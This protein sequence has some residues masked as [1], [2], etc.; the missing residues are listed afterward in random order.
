MICAFAYYKAWD[1]ETG[2]HSKRTYVRDACEKGLF[3]DTPDTTC[4]QFLHIDLNDDTAM[5]ARHA[6]VGQSRRKKACNLEEPH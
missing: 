4:A 1:T 5:S 6:P 3:D 2:R